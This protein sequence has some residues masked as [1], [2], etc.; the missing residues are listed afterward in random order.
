MGLHSQLQPASGKVSLALQCSHPLIRHP[1]KLFALLVTVL[2]FWM[3]F[4]SIG[5]M[6]E[7]V[8]RFYTLAL[9]GIAVMVSVGVGAGLQQIPRHDRWSLTPKIRGTIFSTV[10]LA[11][12]LGWI[13][14]WMAT[15]ADWRTPTDCWDAPLSR[16][17]EFYG[18]DPETGRPQ[19]GGTALRDVE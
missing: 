15:D 8:T 5:G 12:V 10:V 6:A 9:P 1:R 2:P 3:F 13:P 4:R 7:A 17:S 16:I 14:S 11:L 18:A 19:A